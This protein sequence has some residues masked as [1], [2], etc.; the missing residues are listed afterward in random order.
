MSAAVNFTILVLVL[1]TGMTARHVLQ[2]QY[3]QTELF[4]SNTHLP[5]AV[6]MKIRAVAKIQPPLRAVV[7]LD[8]PKMSM[9]KI[10]PKP[11]IKPIQME[12]KTTLPTVKAVTPS[13][14]LAPQPKAA[15]T[16]AAP[17]QRQQIKPSTAPVHFG[18]TFGATLNSNASKSATV[19]AIGNPFGGMDGAAVAQRA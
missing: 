5:P 3:L 6:K 14:I 15:L 17:A 8:V 19:A 18:E 9:L 12:A 1:W 4:L 7:K 11:D 16:A 10:E 13:V 2:H